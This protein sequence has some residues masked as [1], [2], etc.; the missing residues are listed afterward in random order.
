MVMAASAKVS[1]RHGLWLAARV[2][3]LF[4]RKFLSNKKNAAPQELRFTLFVDHRISD[5]SQSIQE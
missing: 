3:F 5:Y 2:N 4:D 1:C